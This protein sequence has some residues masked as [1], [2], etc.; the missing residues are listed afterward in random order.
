[1][2]CCNN[3]NDDD[4]KTNNNR[5]IPEGVKPCCSLR[6][7]RCMCLPYDDHWM[8]IAQVLAIVSVF[9]SWI[10]WVSFIISLVGMFLMQI[11][12]C[13]RQH[14]SMI[15]VSARLAMLCFLLN[16]GVAIYIL[17]AWRKLRYCN[18]F[19]FWGYMFDDDSIFTDD[20]FRS[21]YC[22]EEK[23]AI[24]AFVCGT[25]WAVSSGCLI[26]FLKS[27]RH[28]KWEETHSNRGAKTNNNNTTNDEACAAVELG[29]IPEATAA[30]AQPTVATAI[31][32]TEN[33]K[34][35]I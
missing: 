27:G 10:W 20:S 24:V 18:V 5:E 19:I 1:M 31:L 30:E 16:Y 7:Q 34:E 15:S 6:G 29:R 33:V 8:I 25:L 14:Q 35:D 23:W 9:L 22:E 21:D 28:A 11:L 17:V 4:S 2:R 12:W 32:E 3:D 13:C 26:Y